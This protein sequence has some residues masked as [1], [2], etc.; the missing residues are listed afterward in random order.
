MTEREEFEAWFELTASKNKG[1]HFR[2][3]FEDVAW[4]AWQAALA[5]HEAQPSQPPRATGRPDLFAPVAYEQPA[6]PSQ[7]Q[8]PYA[9]FWFSG[10]EEGVLTMRQ[11]YESHKAKW[12]G[13]R[14]VPVY[15]RG[16]P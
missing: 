3:Y 2:A 12:P 9:W 14:F 11:D 5:A 7:P 10:T 16:P 4:L 8:E 13:L 15:T 1:P 6:Q